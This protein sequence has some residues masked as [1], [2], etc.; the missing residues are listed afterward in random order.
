MD[1]EHELIDDYLRDDNVLS[2]YPRA[3]V[4]PYVQN[5][6]SAQK[7]GSNII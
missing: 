4:L 2:C 7:S 3:I 5:R 6:M 1:K